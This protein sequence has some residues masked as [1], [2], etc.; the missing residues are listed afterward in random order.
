VHVVQLS[1]FLE[2]HARAPEVLLEEWHSLADIARAVASAGHRVSVVQA[3]R[4][5]GRFSRDDVDF[6]FLG[7]VNGAD[8][9]VSNP[10]FLSLLQELRADVLHVHGLGFPRDVIALRRALPGIPIVVQDHADRPPRPWRRFAW[11]RA[12]REVDGVVFCAASQAEPFF[13]SR[14]FADGLRV[15]EAPESTSG[16]TTGDRDA[17]RAATHVDGDPAV[18]WIGHLDANKDPLTALEAVK[19][20][21]R[22]LP[23]IRLHCCFGQA[24]LRA[25]V[26][27]RLARDPGLAQRVRLVGRVPHARI[28]DYLRAADLFLHASHREGSSFALIEALACGV[29]PVVTDIPSLRALTADGRCAFLWTCGDPG[30][31]ARALVAAARDPRMRERA[32][33]REH[34]EREL[35][36]RALGTK[37]A[38][39]YLSSGARHV[40]D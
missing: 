9:I 10:E 25:A 31:A 29:L 36:F 23:G 8:S 2:R 40:R 5:P 32:T 20:A 6:H 16:F 35:S 33:L 21:S 27:A 7:P 26:E 14:I 34:F 24:P 3:N 19:L 17:A 13:R 39:A 38:Q 30:D 22:E 11:R 4:R 12:M 1:F 28:Q 37:L 18:L 15:F